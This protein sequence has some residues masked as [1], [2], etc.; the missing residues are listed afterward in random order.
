MKIKATLSYFNRIEFVFNRRTT[1]F[2]IFSINGSI[3]CEPMNFSS[4]INMIDEVPLGLIYEN[5]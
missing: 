4:Y 2:W 1:Y 3:I 5:K